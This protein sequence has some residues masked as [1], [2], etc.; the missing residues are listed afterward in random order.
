MLW[1]IHTCSFTKSK[2]SFLSRSFSPKDTVRGM[3][4]IL[5]H[6]VSRS[7]NLKYSLLKWVLLVFCN[8]LNVNWDHAWFY[9]ASHVLVDLGWVD[10]DF[11][12]PPSCPAA[13]PLLPRSHHPKQSRADSGTLEIQV[14]KPSLRAHGTPCQVITLV[15]NLNPPTFP[16]VCPPIKATASLSVIRYLTMASM[17][18]L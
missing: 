4:L 15:M 8:L 5:C 2:I 7:I 18:R 16:M 11:C 10:F 14:N 1:I 13:Q 6:I 17:F 9:R 3:W 12:V